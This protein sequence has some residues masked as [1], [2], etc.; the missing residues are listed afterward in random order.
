[1]N[2]GTHEALQIVYPKNKQLWLLN[3]LNDITRWN[4]H[5]YVLV[6]RRPQGRVHATLDRITAHVARSDLFL[7]DAHRN[8]LSLVSME[9]N[10]SGCPSGMSSTSFQS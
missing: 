3:K 5:S 8:P 2:T 4:S 9:S 10:W 1:V 7:G 6:Q